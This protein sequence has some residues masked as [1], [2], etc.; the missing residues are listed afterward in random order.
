MPRR[1]LATE[2]VLREGTPGRIRSSSAPSPVRLLNLYRN[3]SRRLTARQ[4]E[5]T[6]RQ[7]RSLPYGDGVS[8]W[9]LAEIVKAQAAILETDADEDAEQEL[10]RAVA[11]VVE[12]ASEAG[13]IER[14]LRPLI[15][16]AADAEISGDQRAEAFAAWRRF[17]EALAE[18]R[19]LVLV[20]EDL[21]W[22]D[23]G[24]LDFIDASDGRV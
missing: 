9:T 6:W 22:A 17:L 8:F 14:H 16:L 3:G 10:A 24:L 12:Q 13:W 11:D 23:D 5:G 19:P 1:R 18:W 4:A 7:G 20:L 15:G 21:H 2:R